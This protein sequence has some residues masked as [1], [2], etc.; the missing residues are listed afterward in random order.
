MMNNKLKLS[1]IVLPAMFGFICF[2]LSYLLYNT[3]SLFLILSGISYII[4]FLAVMSFLFGKETK[5][6]SQKGWF[7]GAVIFLI[8]LV[9][10]CAAIFNF[11]YQMEKAAKDKYAYLSFSNRYK[12]D[13]SQQFDIPQDV[14]SCANLTLGKSSETWRYSIDSDFYSWLKHGKILTIQNLQNQSAV[15]LIYDGCYFQLNCPEGL[16]HI[17]FILNDF[18]FT[19]D[20]FKSRDALLIVTIVNLYD[21]HSGYHIGEGE[22]KLGQDILVSSWM[23]N[24]KEKVED[25]T[26]LTKHF[27]DIDNNQWRIRFHTFNMNGSV[28]SWDI[29][30]FIKNTNRLHI[31][32]INVIQVREAGSYGWPIVG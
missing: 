5:S 32:E 29:K 2:V 22:L 25:F 17:N 10:L 12:G 1:V 13:D 7:A 8:A 6:K 31:T 24:Q 16:P 28:D 20:D 9:S 26:Q 11:I 19:R 14:I 23:N 15:F 18:E 3:R 27:V 30:G 21:N 4:S